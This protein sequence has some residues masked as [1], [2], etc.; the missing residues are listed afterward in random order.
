MA[1][2]VVPSVVPAVVPEVIPSVVPVVVPVVVP[3]IVPTVV[4]TVVHA[5]VSLGFRSL[6][7]AV[8]TALTFS[9]KSGDCQSEQVR[10][11]VGKPEWEMGIKLYV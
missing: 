10:M 9:Q 3:Q 6:G 7:Q 11:R 2:S 4:T 1:A 8:K 5:V